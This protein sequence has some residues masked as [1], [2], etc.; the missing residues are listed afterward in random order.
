MLLMTYL[1]AIARKFLPTVIR[2]QLR[3][4]HRSFIFLTSLRRFAR[5]PERFVRDDDR[6]LHGL[7][8]GWGNSW[9]ADAS[10]LAGTVRHAFEADGPI[11]ECGSGLTT[12]VLCIIAAKKNVPVLTLEHAAEWAAKVNESLRQAGL[13]SHTVT[14]APLKDYGD[15]AWYDV[16]AVR[17]PDCI[18]LVIC[19]GPPSDTKG[20]R[21]GLLP[22]AHDHLKTGCVILLDDADREGEKTV[23]RRWEIEF[24]TVTQL[25]QGERMYALATCSRPDARALGSSRLH[26]PV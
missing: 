26:S 7:V 16:S 14:T 3:C 10:Y 9:S 21:Y 19:D 5:D 24:S 18:S 17:M 8:Y 13:T 23:L 25:H 20:G 12:L 15:F 4:W 22:V 1:Y 11:L 2:K 6:V